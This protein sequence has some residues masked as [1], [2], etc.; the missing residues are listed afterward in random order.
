MP[1]SQIFVDDGLLFW[2]TFFQGHVPETTRAHHGYETELSLT[3]V[4]Q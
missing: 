2:T 4:W 1:L 3:M